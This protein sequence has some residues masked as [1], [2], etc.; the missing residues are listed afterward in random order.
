MS[1]PAM[2]FK[3]K[4]TGQYFVTSYYKELA[5]GRFKV[6]GEKHDVTDYVESFQKQA[7]DDFAEQIYQRL[8]FGSTDDVLK[9]LEERGIP[10]S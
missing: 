5:G 3:S 4:I 2:I 1:T 10:K 9:L 8:Q 6:T 7:V